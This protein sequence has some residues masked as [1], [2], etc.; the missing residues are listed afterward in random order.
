LSDRIANIFVL[1]EDQEQQNLIRRYLGPLARTARFAS[2]PGKSGSGSHYVLTQFPKQVLTCRGVLGKK[3]KCI[4][5]VMTDADNLTVHGRERTLHDELNLTDRT[6]LAPEEPIVI[7]IPK[8]QVE[9]WIK[10]LLGQAMLEED[11]DSDRPPV[12]STE[13]KT[14]S[15]TLFDWTRNGSQVGETCVPSLRT[16]LPRWQKLR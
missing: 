9:T 13:I 5:I 4:L 11:K 15:E 12:T 1:C 10:C 14:A 16:A 7:L 2:V 3:T 8:W 6:Q